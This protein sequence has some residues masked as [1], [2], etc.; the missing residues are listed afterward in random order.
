VYVVT[1]ITPFSSVNYIC[2]GTVLGNSGGITVAI[3]SK[4]TGSVTLN[5]LD[6]NGAGA[7]PGG[8]DLVCFGQQ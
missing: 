2:V 1:F 6:H 5:V 7:D 4:A 8:V 3:A